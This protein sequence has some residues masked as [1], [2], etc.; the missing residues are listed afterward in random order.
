MLTAAAG[1]TLGSGVACV[2]LRV[3]FMHLR[4]LFCCN[5]LCIEV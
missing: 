2:S 3:L 1:G 5:T 4:L